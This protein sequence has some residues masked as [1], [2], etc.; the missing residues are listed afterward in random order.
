MKGHITN[1]FVMRIK[2]YTIA[3]KALKGD[4]RWLVY[5]RPLIQVEVILSIYC[6]S[7]LDKQQELNIYEIGCA[8]QISYVCCK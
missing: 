1:S 3:S 2:P 7:L 4:S 8:L 6:E 5:M